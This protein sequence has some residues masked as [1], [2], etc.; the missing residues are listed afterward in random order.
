MIPFLMSEPVVVR[1]DG[2]V[3]LTATVDDANPYQ[4]GHFPGFAVFP[5]VF[6]IDLMCRAAAAALGGDAEIHTIR[7]VRFLA[8]ILMRDDVTVAVRTA[9]R[10]EMYATCHRLRRGRSQLAATMSAVFGP[11][12]D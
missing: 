4:A 9:E 3:S 8:P 5:G 11:V 2:V 10:C 7:S 1:E 6:V 12:H